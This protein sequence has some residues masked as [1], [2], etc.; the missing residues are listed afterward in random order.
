MLKLSVFLSLLLSVSVSFADDDE[1]DTGTKN[2]VGSAVKQLDGAQQSK[3]QD[4]L[5]TIKQKQ[6]QEKKILDELDKEDDQ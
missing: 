5:A 1:I 4:Q 2:E 3:L 6:E